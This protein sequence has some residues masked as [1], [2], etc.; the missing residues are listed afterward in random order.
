M[1]VWTYSPP[2]ADQFLRTMRRTLEVKQQSELAGMLSGAKCEFWTD[3]SF[4]RRWD[5]YECTFRLRVPLDRLTK[6]NDK[7]KL[8][9]FNLVEQFLPSEVGYDL[10]KVEVSPFL[11]VEEEAPADDLLADVIKAD[12]EHVKA[13]WE[14]ALGRR[15]IDPEG[16]ITSARTLLESV[17]KLILDENA[18]TYD[19]GLD[20]SKLYKEAAKALKLAPEQHQEQ[21]FKQILSGCISVVEG[22]A[23]LRN[24]LS[25]AHGRAKRA[26]RPEP[27][28]AELAVNLACSMASF[29]MRT[30][31]KRKAE[32]AWP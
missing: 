28:H 11:V 27:R 19:Q 9:L 30:H 5:A 10:I 2:D 12:H 21:I 13:A 18:I 4:G 1:S 8:T 31:V 29:L 32:R 24:S 23:A 22:L 17:C 25:D 6:F 16:A 3:G 7:H 20:L 26:V 15:E 14:K